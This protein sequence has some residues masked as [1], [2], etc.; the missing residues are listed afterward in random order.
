MLISK[1]QSKALYCTKKRLVHFFFLVSPLFE[2]VLLA[3]FSSGYIYLRRK[4]QRRLA[5]VV[6]AS[7]TFGRSNMLE[8]H[9]S[10]LGNHTNVASVRRSNPQAFAFPH[11]DNTS[12]LLSLA[13]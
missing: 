7:R 12:T 4:A 6:E 13:K 1:P 11:R 3:L 8:G 9:N 10:Y 2:P 5:V